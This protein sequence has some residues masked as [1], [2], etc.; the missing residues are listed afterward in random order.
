MCVSADDYGRIEF[1][2]HWLAHCDGLED[3]AKSLDLISSERKTATAGLR[4][5]GLQLVD[6]RINVDDFLLFLIH[7]SSI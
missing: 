2:Q 3:L 4:L 6:D 1:Q 5:S 7:L